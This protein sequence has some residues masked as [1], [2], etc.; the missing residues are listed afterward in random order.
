MNSISSPS[1]SGHSRWSPS[2]AKR[3]M[4]CPASVREAAALP[5]TPPSAYARKGSS[6]AKIA[7]LCIQDDQDPETFVG[8]VVQGEEFTAEDVEPLRIYTSLLRELT[9]PADGIAVPEVRLGLDALWPGLYGHADLLVVGD[10]LTVADLKWGEGVYVDHLENPQLWIYALGALLEYDK[11]QKYKGV[12]VIICQPRYA[13]AEPV[14]RTRILA[15]E[16]WRWAVEELLPALRATEE[17]EPRYEAGE[18]C[19]FCPARPTCPALREYAMAQAQSQ[20]QPI[21]LPASSLGNADLA[22]VLDR[23]AIVESWLR[24]VRDEAL[25]RAQR[26]ETIPG[27]ILGTGRTTREWSDPPIAAATLMDTYGWD[28]AEIFETTLRSPAQVEK[29]LPK[30]ERG[31][32]AGLVTTKPGGVKLVKDDGRQPVPSRVEEDFTLTFLR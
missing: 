30:S 27:Y 13:G 1:A 29:R 3:W 22:R 5:A 32:I 24:A 2:A 19:R 25:E 10:T 14:R 23:A 16:L 28:E 12:D 17:R 8:R 9:A 6:V 7:E 4:T 20:F 15:S 31:V 11:E 21:P 26:G 18:H